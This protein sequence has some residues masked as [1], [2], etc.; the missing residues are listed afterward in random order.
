MNDSELRNLVEAALLTAGRPLSVKNLLG[1]F[2]L[3]GRPSAANIHKALVQLQES[4]STRGV[5]LVEVADGFRYQARP[6]LEPRLRGLLEDRPR[7]YSRALLET[8]ALIAY[9]QPITRGEIEEVRGVTLSGQII[10]TLEDRDW[11]KVVGYR[12]TPGRPALLGTTQTFLNDFCLQSL[13]GLPVLREQEEPEISS[14]EMEPPA[15]EEISSPEVAETEAISAAE[16]EEQGPAAAE[17]LKRLAPEPE[18][19][20]PA[21]DPP[22]GD[23]S[24]SASPRSNLYRLP[25]SKPQDQD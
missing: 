2:P 13:E 14:G 18:E 22:P 7:K 1:L 24:A 20:M 9:R 4:C 23:Q 5:E 19:Q 11:I 10:R 15:G 8:L 12:Q 6:E 21:A 17:E 3:R 25:S 16:E